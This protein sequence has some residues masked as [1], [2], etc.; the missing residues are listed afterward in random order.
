MRA[1]CASGSA[2]ATADRALY[3]LASLDATLPVPATGTRA[4]RLHGPL[5]ARAPAATPRSGRRNLDAGQPARST[6]PRCG[7]P[8]RGGHPEFRIPARRG[9]GFS[10]R[11]E[12]RPATLGRGL[13]DRPSRWSARGELLEPGEVRLS[14]GE[15]YRSPWLVSAW[16]DDGLDGLTRRFHGFVRARRPLGERKVML[17]T[18]E[19]VY[20]DHDLEKLTR[21]AETAAR[22]RCRT[23]RAR[24]RLDDRPYR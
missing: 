12:R 21:L 2:C 24:R 11:V 5:A 6:R 3:S 20:F 8:A 18:W 19:A 14:P 16:S 23:L 7:L 22:R 13:R 15:S 1:C 4:A 9:M 10:P 17:N